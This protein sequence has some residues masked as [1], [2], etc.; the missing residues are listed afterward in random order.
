[1]SLDFGRQKRRGLLAD[2]VYP[3][4]TTEGQSQERAESARP[5]EDTNL[6]EMGE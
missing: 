2:H 3:L 5:R 6:S 1:M 4:E